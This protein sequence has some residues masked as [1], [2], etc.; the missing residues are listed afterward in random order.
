M[1]EQRYSDDGFVE[2]AFS[3]R[4]TSGALPPTSLAVAAWL[5]L[6][7]LLV[8][9]GGIESAEIAVSEVEAVETAAPVPESTV[10]PVAN[11][12]S[13]SEPDPFSSEPGS[14]TSIGPARTTTAHDF[15]APVSEAQPENGPEVLP[16]P[17][18]VPLEDRSDGGPASALNNDQDPPRPQV[19]HAH[20]DGD[21]AVI[22]SGLD[23]ADT[24]Q[25]DAVQRNEV[26]SPGPTPSKGTMFTWHDGD[27]LASIWQ[28]TQL[29]V[30]DVIT[31][32]GWDDP[33]GPVFWSDSDQLM[34][35]PGGVVLVLDPTWNTTAVEAFLSSNNIDP[36][37]A[38]AF[39][40]LP[41]WFL[42]ETAPGFPSL[43]LANALAGQG[44]VV[45]SSPNWWI[46]GLIE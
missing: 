8:A 24:A 34:A 20:L 28:D 21:N 11:P 25:V 4:R 46:E 14:S 43:Q 2:G 12:D 22:I 35:L 38:E 45:I 32:G 29:V 36:S 23:E 26:V 30:S 39:E 37:D 7:G 40:G 9:C 41:N 27:R 31:E 13:S 10:P 6:V 19:L 16:L 17:A 5:V 33:S 3:I 42:V 1:R 18:A 15:F 44:G